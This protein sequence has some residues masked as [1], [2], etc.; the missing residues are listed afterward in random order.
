MRYKLFH[1]PLVLSIICITSCEKETVTERLS[2]YQNPGAH[3][4]EIMEVA[5]DDTDYRVYMPVINEMAL[6]V[7]VWGNGS[8]ALPDNYDDTFRHLASHGYLVIDSYDKNTGTGK[9]I[10]DAIG[11][12]TA[13]D[14]SET[15]LLYHKIDTSRIALVGHSQGSTGVINAYTNFNQHVNIKTIVSIALPA[16]YW[17]DPEDK[18]D[19]SKI[20]TP[21]LILSGTNDYIVSPTRTNEIAFDATSDIPAA[22]L[23][24]KKAGHNEIQEYSNKYLKYLAAWLDFHLNNAPSAQGIFDGGGEA[25]IRS[26]NELKSIATKGI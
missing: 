24:V 15:S 22:M 13:L 12:I 1:L 20:T 8:E 2:Y 11:A 14:T 25:E 10:S 17:C 4:I 23:M 3:P 9:T 21:F 26:Q 19:A 16:L 18:F 5:F 6:P 7:I